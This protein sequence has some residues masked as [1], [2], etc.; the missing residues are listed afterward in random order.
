MVLYFSGTGNSRYAAEKIAQISGDELI[1]INERI[2]S[3]DHS[4]ISSD[5]PLVFVGP[6]YAGRFPRIMDDY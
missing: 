4:G 1:S 3:G 2:K 6:V 5:K